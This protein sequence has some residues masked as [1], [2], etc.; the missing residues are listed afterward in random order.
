MCAFPSVCSFALQNFRMSLSWARLIPD[1]RGQVN[2]AGVA[3]YNRVF[4]ALEDAGITPW[5][6]LYHWD[7]PQ[8]GS[9]PIPSPHIF[10]VDPVGLPTSCRLVPRHNLFHCESRIL[11]F[12][13]AF[14]VVHADYIAYCFDSLQELACVGAGHGTWAP[15][16]GYW[17]IRASTQTCAR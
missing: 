8:V 7:M 16:S 5:I 17:R 14:W 4:D 15:K 1:G 6:L 11:N 2:K 13:P 9:P 12:A 3:F 10:L